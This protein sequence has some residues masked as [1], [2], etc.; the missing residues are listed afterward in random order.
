MEGVETVLLLNK[1]VHHS[2]FEE[3]AKRKL[4]SRIHIGKFNSYE[5]SAFNLSFY[6]AKDYEFNY[7]VE[8]WRFIHFAEVK[9]SEEIIFIH[10]IPKVIYE[11]LKNHTFYEIID[12]ITNYYCLLDFYSKGLNKGIIEKKILPF[13]WDVT[14]N[15]LKQIENTLPSSKEIKDVDFLIKRFNIS[16]N[17]ER[18]FYLIKY[19]TFHIRKYGSYQIEP[20]LFNFVDSTKAL[21]ENWSSIVDR[22]DFKLKSFTTRTGFINLE[23]NRLEL[24]PKNSRITD[25]YLNIWKYFYTNDFTLNEN[26]FEN[27]VIVSESVVES[28]NPLLCGGYVEGKKCYKP[29]DFENKFYFLNFDKK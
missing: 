22:W 12:Q 24:S 3:D 15:K 21:N 2:F 5:A 18:D 6:I 8:L 7:W 26:I 14:K 9:P 17:D 27:V 1:H 16:L 20:F 11:W 10:E 23:F 25:K 29:L 28:K 13:L 19:W 4:L